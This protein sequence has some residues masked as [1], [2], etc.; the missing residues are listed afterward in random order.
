[1][2]KRKA[3]KK[4]MITTLTV[5][6]LLAIYL[7]PSNDIVNNLNSKVKVKYS[8]SVQKINI[9][10]L[11]DENLL[12]RTVTMIDRDKQLIDKAKCVLNN[13]IDSSNDLLPNGLNGVIPKKTK[14]L[15]INHTEGIVNVNFSQELLN[16]DS[17]KKEKML[18]AI[19]F[20]LLEIEGVGGVV[21][22]VDGAD[23]NTIWKDDKLPSVF[24]KD[25]GIN[26]K[27]DIK[28][29]KDIQK[30]VI[31]YI[32][33]IDKE[34]YYVPITKYVDDNREKIS[35]VIDDLSSNYIYEP[36]LVS[37]LNQKT[38]LI[39][40]EVDS[41]TMI[42]NFNTSIFMSDKEILEEVVYSISYSVFDNYDV[43]EVVFKVNNEEIL[44]KAL[45]DI[46]FVK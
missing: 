25:Y 7:M 30:V 37:Y 14:I 8:D 38:E 36:N 24:T 1:M 12:V 9:Y 32:E 15:D 19:T 34:K 43:D 21:I 22:K 42:L 10:L 11:N 2:L 20:S 45:K 44:K 33:E 16:I 39:N 6:L 35:I 46:E 4:I 28:R 17:N 3:L 5:C 18:E 41:D 27:Y 29:T 31:Y 40:F 13:L 23:I 26:K